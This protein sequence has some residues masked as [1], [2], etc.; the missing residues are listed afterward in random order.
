MKANFEKKYHEIETEHFWFKSRRRYIRDLLNSL[1]RDAKILD[2]G[3]SS[4]ILLNELLEDGFKKEN[5]YGIDVSEKAIANAKA[6]GLV[7]VFVMDAEKI[8]LEVEFDVVI[9]S[10][11]LEHLKNDVVAL[12]N[13]YNLVSLRGQIMVFVPAFMSLWSPHDEVNLHYRR[14][15]LSQLKSKMQEAGFRISKASYWN[16]L[17]FTPVY[18]ARKLRNLSNKKNTTGDLGGIPKANG[19]LFKIINAENKLLQ[20]VS[21]PFGVSTFCIA[22]K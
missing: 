15:T 10:D 19:L 8:A 2:I 14:Y 5:L 20:R 16:F 4:G 12:Q 9:A 1:P 21:F 7:H 13:W 3:C 18:L 22:R 11:C 17:L 6:N